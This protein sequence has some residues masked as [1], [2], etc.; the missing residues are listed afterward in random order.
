MNMYFGAATSSHQVEGGNNNN[1]SVW[2]EKTA[3]RLALEAEHNFGHL[4]TWPEI[5]FQAQ[6]PRNYISG[7]AC[8]HYNRF[9]EDFNLAKSLGHNAHHFSIEWSRIEPEEG[10]FNQDEIEHYRKVVSALRAH[11]LEPFITLWH[12]TL[13]LWLAEQNGVQNKKFPQY[14]ERYARTI[15]AAL[16]TEVKFWITFNEPEVYVLNS[17]FRGIWPPQHK[18][19]FSFYRTVAQLIRAH[20]RIYQIL[21]NQFPFASIGIVCNLSYF[22][23]AGGLINSL[24]KV[25]AERIWN[26]HI[27]GHLKREIDFIGL[28][29]YFHNR[30]NFG[31]NRNRNE[32]VSDMG[33]EIYPN[34]IYHVIK[35]LQ[36]Y[37]LPIYI[38]ENGIADAKDAQRASFIREHLDWVRKAIDEK[39]NVQGY[40]YW[41]L[42]DNFE[43]D[44]GFWPRF[45]LIEVDYAT[46]ERKIRPSAWEYKKIIENW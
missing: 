1:W 46:Q 39:Y 31:F 36:H 37:N 10:Q 29:Y 30:I 3:E 7:M 35:D 25:G 42:L 15:M 4:Y 33:W 27:L 44:K 11:G 40:F 24:L 28:N 38:T 41:S 26:H 20:K 17:Y 19:I 32:Q 8:D 9:A 13:P 5:K 43:W 21:K 6:N 18:G 22:E 45:G 14:F 34:G 23:S 16:G 2:E 12:W